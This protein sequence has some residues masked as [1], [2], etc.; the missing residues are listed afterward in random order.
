MFMKIK[1]KALYVLLAIIILGT[2]C[3]NEDEGPKIDKIQF[4]EKTRTIKIGETS[5]AA[6]KVSPESAKAAEK[7]K[8]EV[9]AGSHIITIDENFSSN[10]GVVFTGIMSGT[11]VIKAKARNAV[12]YLNVIVEGSS[13]TSTPYITVTDSVLEVPLGTKKHFMATLQNGNP[14]DYLSFV[15]SNRERDIVNYETAN[16]TVVIEGLR[17]GSDV[18]TARHPKAQYGADVLV[19]VLEA[20]EYAR[21]ITGENAVFMD[22]GQEMA[23]YT[24]LVG[25][26]ESETGYSVYQVSEGND[27]ITVT[28]SGEFCYITSKKE[29]VAK[30]RVSNR[31]APYPFEFQV[32]VRGK[33]NS[34]YI[35]MSSNFV[36]LEDSSIRN[37]YAYYNGDSEADIDDKYYCYFENGVTD[38]AEVIRYGNCF[39]LR[40]LKNGNVKLIVENEYSPVRQEVLIQVKLEELSYGEMIITTSQNVIYMELGGIDV[41]L[42]MKLVGG[43]PADRNSFEWTV[44]DS[45]I[46]SADVPDGHGTAVHRAMINYG[47]IQEAEAKI[48]AK[49]A[50]T[51]YITVTNPK[52]PLS[53]A[54]VLVKV[55]PKGMFSGNTVSLSGPGLLKVKRGE[56]LEA[57][58]QLIGGSYQNTGGLVWHVKD[59]SV[60]E[61]DGAGLKGV[62]TGIKEG[63]TQLTVSGPNVLTEYHAI[64]V[65]YEEDNEDVMPYVYAD[66]LQYKMYAGQTVMAWIYH[67]NIEDSK[68]DFSIINTNQRAAYAVKQGDIIII[69]AVEPGEAELL[70]RTGIPQCNDITLMVSVELAEL[71]TERPYV[72][73]SENNFVVTYVGGTAEY[74]VSM[75]GASVSDLSKILWTIDDDSVVAI[76]MK[77]GANVVLKGL[78]TGQTVLRA[79]SAKSANVKEV[80]VFVTA[81]KND[82]DTKIT[83]GLAKINYVLE[84]G[85]SFFV[86]LVTNASE[87][88]K[89]QIRWQKSDADILDVQDNYDTAY[90]TALQ[91]GTCIITVDTRD[92]SHAMKLTLYVT[93]RSPAYQEIEFG[94]PSSVVLL[95]G[96]SKI[97]R[98]NVLGGFSGAFNFMWNIEDDNVAHVIGNGL[99]ATLWGRNAG[100]SFLTVSHYGF[101]KKILVICVENE[102]DLE[103]IFY[104]TADK[105]YCRIKRGEEARVNLLFGENGFPEDDKKNIEW[106][107]ELNGGIITLSYSGANAKITGKNPGVARIIA[108]HEKVSKDVEILIEVIDSVIGSEEYYMQFPAVIRLLKDMPQDIAISLYKDGHLYTQGYSLITA[109][110]EGK[111]IVRADPLNDTLRVM[112]YAAGQEYIT[113][114]HP[115]AGEYRMLAAVYEGEIPSEGDPVIYVDRQYWS[116]YESKETHIALQIAGGDENTANGIRWENFDPNVISV[117]SSNKSRARVKG[118]AF[119]GTEIDIT[120]NGKPVERIYV[121]VAKGDVNTDIAVSTE[122]IIIM[123]LDTDNQHRTRVIGGANAQYW[124][125]KIENEGVAE[126]RAYA[127]QC[128]LYPKTAGMTELVISG[129]GCERKIIVVVVQSEK[130]KMEAR[131]LNVDKRYFKLKRGESTVIY[132]YYKMARP[133]T[134]MNNP[135][136]RYDS[137]VVSA[138]LEDGGYVIT[139]KNEGIEIIT[140]SNDDCENKKI[141]IAVEVS[142]ILAGGITENTSLVY[143]TTENNIILAPPGLYGILVKIDIIGEYRGTNVDFIWSKDSILIEWE[144]SGLLAFI[145]TKETAGEVNITV[146][147]KYCEYPLRIKV[148][149]QDDYKDSGTPYVYSDRTVYR[150]GLIDDALHVSF[151]INNANDVDYSKVVF[152]KTG[153][154]VDLSLNGDYF[155]VR[156]RTQ[157]V[158]ELEIFYPG[159]V[160][161]KLFFI[162]SDNIKNA[163]VYLT[164]A[165]NYVVVPKSRTKVVDVALINHTEFNSENIKWF[166]SD[167]NTVTVVGTGKTVQIYGAELGFAKLTVTHPAS[168]N[169][170]EIMVKVVEEHDMS[171]VA[172][173]TT[174]DNIIETFVQNNSLQIMVEKIGGKMPGIETSWITDNPSVVSVSGSGNMGYIVP[175]KAGMA[176]VTVTERE[177]EK[178]DIVVIVK[179]VMAGTEYLTTEESVVQLYPG[180]I[181]HPLQVRLVGGNDTTDL[182]DFEWQVYSQLPSDWEV[183]KNGGTVI[184]LFGMGDRAAVSANY[185]GTARVRVSHPKAQLPLYIVV[186]VTNFESMEFNE[187]QAVIANGDIYFAGIKIPN[188]ENFTGKVEYSTDNPAVCVVTG[189]DRVALLQSQG[190]GKAKITA[191]VRGTGLQ[192]SIDVQ[193]I[194][195]DNFAEPNIIISKTTYMLNPRERPFQIEAYLQGV[196]VTEE[197]RYGIKWE[198][199]LLNGG[200]IEEVMSI[201]PG[202]PEIFYLPVSI[203]KPAPIK[204]L[205]GTGPVIQI[206]ILNPPLSQ[207]QPFETKEIVIVASQPEITT[208]TKAV[209]IKI[210]EVS[211]LFTLSKLDISM[212]PGDMADL[213]CAILGGKPSDYK[214]VVW[215]AET[216]NGR[217]IV[218]VMPDKGQDIKVLAV[219]DGTVYVTAMYRNEIA[220]CRVQVKSSFYL[221]L[222]YEIYL[223]YPGARREGNQLVEVE[224]EVRP[225]TQQVMWTPQGP[226]PDADDPVARVVASTQDYSTGKGKIT[227]DPVK[228]GSFTLIGL[229]NRSTARMTVIIQDV[230]RMQIPNNRFFMQPGSATT[231]ENPQPLVPWDYDSRYKPVE[232]RNDNQVKI[233]NSIYIPFTFCPPDYRI[234][235]DSAS[236]TK[237]NNYGIRYEISPVLR[238]NDLEGRGI[239]KLTVTRE[240]PNGEYG[241]R[242]EGMILALEMKKPFEETLIDPSLYSSNPDYPNN[243]IYIKSQLPLHHTMAIPVFQRV[244]GFYSNYDNKN[245]KYKYYDGSDNEWNYVNK[246]NLTNAGSNS[247]GGFDVNNQTW[248]YR[249]TGVLP[250]FDSASYKES[251]SEYMTLAQPYVK[252]TDGR[253]ELTYNL[254]IGDGEDHYIIL[255]RTHQGMYYEFD[256]NT[257]KIA[258]DSFNATIKNHAFYRGKEDI[259][260]PMAFLEDYNGS[261]AIR[262]TGGQDFIVYDRVFIKDRKKVTLEYYSLASNGEGRQYDVSKPSG[263]KIN[264]SSNYDEYVEGLLLKDY[265]LVRQF[266]IP[267]NMNQN[268]VN[269]GI[270][271]IESQDENGKSFYLLDDKSVLDDITVCQIVYWKHGKRPIRVRYVY[272]R[273][274]EWHNLIEIISSDGGPV[275]FYDAKSYFANNKTSAGDD[276]YVTKPDGKGDYFIKNVN[277]DEGHSYFLNSTISQINT[278]SFVAYDSRSHQ[279]MVSYNPHFEDIFN[280]T[281]YIVSDF[282]LGT[283][284]NTE[285][286]M[287]YTGGDDYSLV[288]APGGFIQQNGSVTPYLGD[289]YVR[290][291]KSY[292]LRY[293]YLFRFYD[294]QGPKNERYMWFFDEGA[295]RDDNGVYFNLHNGFRYNQDWN[296]KSTRYF[297]EREGLLTDIVM[298]GTNR[299]F[300]QTSSIL[301]SNTQNRYYPILDSANLDLATILHNPTPVNWRAI[302]SVLKHNNDN[303]EYTTIIDKLDTAESAEEF[304]K[305]YDGNSGDTSKR[306]TP[307]E[308]TSLFNIVAWGNEKGQILLDS[309]TGFIHTGT[310]SYAST[311]FMSHTVYVK[312]EIERGYNRIHNLEDFA[313]EVF[314]M[315]FSFESY[316]GFGYLM[317]EDFTDRNMYDPFSTKSNSVV[318]TRPSVNLSLQ[319]KNSYSN[320]NVINI[321]VTHKVRSGVHLDN[322][323]GGKYV[324]DDWENM[325]KAKNLPSPFVNNS[326]S[327]RKYY[328]YFFFPKGDKY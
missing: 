229:T 124:E 316:K 71:N 148:I 257:T 9:T 276:L 258:I 2:A 302:K 73:T 202:G 110:T 125:W 99:D 288:Y 270:K 167:Y 264:A 143:M 161:L 70:I 322:G 312:R 104:F 285:H 31:S 283:Y 310:Q 301:Y 246:N 55:Y 95:K 76:E 66:R 186:Q 116:V 30:V 309:S 274:P 134:K 235:F 227:I 184:S 321:N 88:Q 129:P 192:A 86:K 149:I 145:N 141:E 121:S 122:S 191:I 290:L 160:S 111:G 16:N 205:R 20:G 298:E 284:N 296:I 273:I 218:K 90:I 28:G 60:A 79:E 194:E 297:F 318:F 85:E 280:G 286:Y 69:N 13:H 188:Y 93:V 232:E 158:S 209:Y 214:E 289:I 277:G 185:V 223:T 151:K 222:Q 147:N 126:I 200:D 137:G 23:Y 18:I 113:L 146:E 175:R 84:A 101:S 15:Y 261:K 35:T 47:E 67:P 211:G 303:R 201:F 96:Q 213:S 251:T 1:N 152:D 182:Q 65:V 24:R 198:A 307:V 221:K 225:F 82:A 173:L 157:G 216:D 115:L 136:L 263:V 83:L 267:L 5:A 41:I 19:F 34:G 174:N 8:Y 77:N 269:G 10:D 58:T 75:A 128:V 272:S 139:G 242:G 78:K 197:S 154:A 42:K 271:Y 118:L 169:D 32:I 22:A 187:K 92:N 240:I 109:R 7:I 278:N 100:Q 294:R 123:A 328:G 281:L 98:G 234:G 135:L 159:A 238:K 119:G 299:N 212:E 199:M 180:Q 33:E 228:E 314:P 37:I 36:I 320:N 250:E 81:T 133:E 91:E 45:A 265:K 56:T 103:N 245:Y 208:R 89:L 21:Y 255:D 80:V 46:I 102:S 204:V 176:K 268:Q 230:F 105:S 317:S 4:L 107:E 259:R 114:S 262:I 193:V 304:K 266:G 150:L 144:A 166:S 162:V 131:Y 163:A 130:E 324:R 189:S 183:A 40:A 326:S 279:T 179:E 170:L 127:D 62:L 236:V 156:P 244:S 282:D 153:N 206:E 291:E 6:I 325:Q 165:M 112:G 224:F 132:P 241:E 94:F 210:A 177:A 29:G 39:A 220:E 233:G 97:I 26:G 181:N 106:K 308:R 207:G 138:V 171:N 237:M 51:T 196:G 323:D 140:I 48:T 43:T 17:P 249:P 3:H 38:I 315:Q 44:E 164:T 25:I 172:Y 57:E 74:S 275:E 50:G 293:R 168:Y 61:A 59:E 215:F 68:F 252:S 243:H 253:H 108:S 239:I 247:N 117:D 305:R 260:A 231:Y 190:V 87:T 292:N 287:W 52:A 11:A 295:S 219:H 300:I 254:E 203:G 54:R 12:D 72:I 14:D 195:R 63:V 311:N 49:K 306:L 142:N 53:E 120:L 155:E 319:Y 27:V 256:E 248:I 178:L 226:T 217:E 313:L 327:F 64:I